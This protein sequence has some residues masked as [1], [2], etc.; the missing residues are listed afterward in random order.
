MTILMIWAKN[1]LA[2][3]GA[4]DGYVEPSWTQLPPPSVDLNSP[5]AGCVASPENCE[6]SR[7]LVPT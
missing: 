7:L 5:A 4:L 1:M 3:L 6:P 2:L